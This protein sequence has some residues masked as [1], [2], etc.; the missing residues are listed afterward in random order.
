MGKITY[1]NNWREK[2]LLNN[3]IKRKR[4]IISMVFN[5]YV[6]SFIFFSFCFI[7]LVCL[8]SL[9]GIFFNITLVAEIDND[10]C[11]ILKKYTTPFAGWASKNSRKG[12][13]Y[14]KLHTCVSAAETRGTTHWSRRASSRGNGEELITT[15][16]PDLTI[17]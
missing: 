17:Y 4:N 16:T 14:E 7:V 9:F 3:D 5:Y 10:F 12:T 15:S 2:H 1:Y 13:V 6:Y 8:Y 11:S